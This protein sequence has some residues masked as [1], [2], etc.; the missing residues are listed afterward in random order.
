MENTYWN[1]AGKLQEDYTRLTAFVP[2]SGESDTVAG[3]LLRACTRLAYDLYNNGMGNNTSG[4]LN[5]LYNKG[6]INR[7]LQTIIEPYTLGRLYSGNYTGDEL[8]VSIEE[9]VTQTVQHILDRPQLL[10]QDNT[11]SMFDYEDEEQH[12][13]EECDDVADGSWGS[14]CQSC[15]DWIEDQEEINSWEE[16][17]SED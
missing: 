14:H 4:A 11:E 5:F 13:C 16:N 8:Q 3:E 12:Y 2:A 17:D 1:G 9:V 7:T 10:E 15:E 6:V